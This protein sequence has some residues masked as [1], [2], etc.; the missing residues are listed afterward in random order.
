MAA[1]VVEV[2]GLA[3]PEELHSLLRVG[4]EGALHRHLGR[5]RL[6]DRVAQRHLLQVDG[7]GRLHLPAREL[8]HLLRLRPLVDSSVEH[9][10]IGQVE[11]RLRSELQRQERPVHL[12]APGR[13]EQHLAVLHAELAQQFGQLHVAQVE[14]RRERQRRLGQVELGAPAHRPSPYGNVEPVHLH[15]LG[16]DVEAQPRVAGRESLQLQRLEPQITAHPRTAAAQRHG[17]VGGEPALHAAQEAGDEARRGRG[18]VVDAQ[19]G[20]HLQLGMAEV[21]KLSFHEEGNVGTDHVGARELHR[22]GTA[23]IDPGAGAGGDE[24]DGAPR[25]LHA[26]A[27]RAD[28]D[29]EQA[30][31]SFHPQGGVGDV[32]AH[33][34]GPDFHAGFAHLHAAELEAVEH[35]GQALPA[36]RR[37]GARLVERQVQHGMIDLQP[38]QPYLLQQRLDGHLR[39][40]AL[41]LEVDAPAGGAGPQPLDGQFALLGLHRAARHFH[42]SGGGLLDGGDGVGAE[43]VGDEVGAQESQRAEGRD[44]GGETQREED[45]AQHGS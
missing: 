3:V 20:R 19:V 39:E 22:S 27:A 35:V 42:L 38:L 25:Q 45:A 23:Q 6:H 36:R 11:A 4:E 1:E 9:G 15:G 16:R 31:L 30:A 21:G 29:L 33:A 7:D 32:D 43:I 13:P 8:E 14:V 10:E 44:G 2:D 5:A 26:P 41:H 24:R 40:H 37:R 34:G 28:A 18:Q 12:H 17:R